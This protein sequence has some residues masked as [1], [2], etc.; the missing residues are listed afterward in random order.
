M[1][2]RFPDLRI[3]FAEVGAA[4]VPPF[5][6]AADSNYLRHHYWAEVELP[7]LPSHYIKRNFLFGIQDDTLAVRR[8]VDE[9]GPLGDRLE[10]AMSAGG[11]AL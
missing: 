9:I 3:A 7:H 1:L 5:A 2:D 4:W 10:K 6:E 8:L 11:D